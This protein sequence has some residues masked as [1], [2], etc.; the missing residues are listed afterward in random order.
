MTVEFSCSSRCAPSGRA[1]AARVE[2]EY[3]HII[4]LREELAVR[5]D[6]FPG[7]KQALAAAGRK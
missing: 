1:S 4:T 6:G 2:A 7:W 5:V 3:A